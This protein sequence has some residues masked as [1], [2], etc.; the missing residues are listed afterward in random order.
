VTELNDRDLCYDLYRHL[1]EIKEETALLRAYVHW[2]KLKPKRGQKFASDEHRPRIYRGGLV[3]E[4][5]RL[6]PMD[7]AGHFTSVL[8]SRGRSR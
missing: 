8:S 4:L 2:L 5:Q 7:A 1:W 3:A 6:L